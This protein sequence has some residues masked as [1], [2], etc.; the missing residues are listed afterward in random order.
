VRRLLVAL[1]VVVGLVAAADVGFRLWA[2]AAVAARM[3]EAAE[4]PERPDVDLH[5]FPFTLQ[6]LRSR[7]DRVDV[8]ME[9][10]EASGLMLES[11]R[12]ELRDV[13]FPAGRLFTRGGGTI[14][15]REGTGVVEVTDDAVTA[16]LRGDGTPI[17]VRFLGPEVRATGSV[18]ALGQELT[19]SASGTMAISEGSLVFR[20]EEIEV[21]G[22][23]RI[24]IGLL[25]FEVPLPQ[26]VEGVTLDRIE[27]QD[28]VARLEG[29]LR[30]VAFRIP[31]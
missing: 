16:Y 31:A 26:P 11:I 14:R 24:H 29:D 3:Q 5:G 30:R 20:P 2:E 17:E 1:V 6:V 10:V 8:S 12:L 18:T 19:A 28:G 7:F 21:P 13:R 9:G 22:G 23:I 15:P 25:A 4:L 27:V